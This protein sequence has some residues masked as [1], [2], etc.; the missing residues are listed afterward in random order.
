MLFLSHYLLWDFGSEIIAKVSMGYFVQLFVESL[1]I[2]EANES[3]KAYNTIY[4]SKTYSLSGLE[5]DTGNSIDL[6]FTL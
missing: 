5:S 1:V 6:A 2:S 4:I 3:Q